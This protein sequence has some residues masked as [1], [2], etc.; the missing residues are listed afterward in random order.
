MTEI[1]QSFLHLYKSR[2]GVE[3]LSV[4]KLPVSGSYRSYYR[5]VGIYETVI[6]A[7]NEDFREN[8]AFIAFTNHFRS[9][10]LPVPQ[11]LASD[12]GNRIYMITDLGDTTLF[13][14]LTEQRSNEGSGQHNL[15]S[16]RPTVQFPPEIMEIYKKAIGWLPVF[17]IKAGKSLDYSVCYPRLAFDRQSMMWDL[18]YFKYYFLKLAKI[19]FDEQA[20]EEDFISLCDMLLK[21]DADFFLYRDFQSRNIMVIQGEPWFIDYQ[22]GRRGALQYDI[23]SL[24]ADG[25]ADIPMAVRAELLAHYL[26]KL[27][28][29]YPINRENFLKS[30]DSFVLVRILQALGAYGFR[31][32]YENKPHFLQSI[33]FALRNLRYFRA[34]GKLDF[35][36]KTLMKV[37]D[38]M[39]DT[40]ALNIQQSVEINGN[41][42]NVNNK[43]Q[44]IASSKDISKVLTVTIQSFSYKKPVPGDETGHGGG[45]VFDCRALPNPGRFA[46]FRQFN[47]K[48]QPVIDYLGKEPAV[49]EFLGY[50]CSLVGQSVRTYIDREFDHL[51]VSF[52]CTGGQ[53]RSVYC[54]EKLATYLK[55]KYQITIQVTHLEQ[56]TP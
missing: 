38:A 17:Q 32:Y 27:T 8:E 41:K 42:N 14:L 48:D 10:G 20:L 7:H 26:D 5:L 30:Y 37:I 3:P 15:R 24:L 9:E 28:G 54:A 29:I 55:N 4:T 13:Q 1:E 56:K 36:L 25:K 51:Q 12:P 35:G 46:E 21:A 2:Y 40:P 33:P 11:I 23:A 52:G 44:N 19:P 16:E 49:G 47:G 31:G 22:G 34:T 50:V 45:F 39:V 43:L 53:H 18:N 6:G